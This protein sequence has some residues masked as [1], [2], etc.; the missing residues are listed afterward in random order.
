[1]KK[2]QRQ[3]DRGDHPIRRWVDMIHG[4]AASVDASQAA[5]R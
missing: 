4:A 3:N 2:S 5:L 1:M